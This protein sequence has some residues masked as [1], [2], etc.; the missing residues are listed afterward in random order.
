LEVVPADFA[1]VLVNDR[2]KSYDA[3][4]LAGLQQQKCLAHLLRNVSQVIDRKRGMARQFGRTLKTL[5]R[6]SLDLWKARPNFSPDQYH[7]QAQQ[8][9]QRLT[10]HLRNRMLRDDD[11]QRLL[12]G[13][14]TQNDRGHLLRFLFQTGLEPTNNRA[15]R[16]LRPAVIARKVSHCSKN[17]RGAE[18]FA[19]F[20]SVLQ[21]ARKTSPASLTQNVLACLSPTPFLVRPR[22]YVYTTCYTPIPR[23]RSSS[24]T[25]SLRG[26]D[27]SQ[28][29]S[30][31]SFP[32]RG[33]A[34]AESLP[35]ASRYSALLIVGLERDGLADGEQI[36]APNGDLAPAFSLLSRSSPIVA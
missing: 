24:F 21:T 32:R 16:M 15:E 11:N 19:A 25:P 2:G 35:G 8:L 6:Q 33:P 12:N 26:T 4:E 9:E 30:P 23:P 7:A 18:A 22:C 1:G 29:I 27:S 10:H 28:H 34:E 5:L 36:S 3:Q 31:E 17:Q 14:G 20:V 13:I